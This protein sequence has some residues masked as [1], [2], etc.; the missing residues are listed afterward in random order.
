MFCQYVSPSSQK[1][2]TECVDTVIT[3][4]SQYK[5]VNKT[6]AWDRSVTRCSVCTSPLRR[7]MSLKCFVSCPSFSNCFFFGAIHK[8]SVYFL[9]RSSW[10]WAVEVICSSAPMTVRYSFGFSVE[11]LSDTVLWLPVLLSR[12]QVQASS[13]LAALHWLYWHRVKGKEAWHLI[14]QHQA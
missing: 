2:V 4:L 3:T 13:L 7:D 9:K 8:N 10:K 11:Y 5:D 1:W 12:L 14:K 6:M